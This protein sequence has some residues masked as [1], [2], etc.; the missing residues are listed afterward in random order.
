MLSRATKEEPAALEQLPRLLLHPS[1][2]QDANSIVNLSRQLS[3]DNSNGLALFQR[4]HAGALM[5]ILDQIQSQKHSDPLEN[6]L[7]ETLQMTIMRPPI[8]S[9][10][11]V[12]QPS[13]GT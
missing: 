4:Q 3:L 9:F 7:L 13:I 8:N 12:R 11:A 2:W 5:S 1:S 10:S 6:L